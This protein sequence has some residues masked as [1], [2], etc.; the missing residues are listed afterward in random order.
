MPEFEPM[1][2]ELC[3]WSLILRRW[4]LSDSEAVRGLW[5]ERDKRS[6]HL[7][8]SSGRPSVAEMSDRI[9]TQLDEAERTGFELLAI[10]RKSVPGF[11]GY[12]GLTVGAATTAEP[13]IAYELYRA[14][15]GQGYATEAARAI[16]DATR[17][18]GRSRLWATVREWNAASL[19][20]LSKLDF[21]DSGR[22]TQDPTR[23]DSVWMTREL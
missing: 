6:L 2:Q 1:C 23:G 9:A 22:R 18:T 10:E 7:I 16:V 4:R 5:V 12:C 13:E 15:Y 19:N 20:V 11:I 8:D 17:E 3:T 14:V 21:V